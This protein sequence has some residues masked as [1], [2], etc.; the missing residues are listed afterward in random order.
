MHWAEIYNMPNISFR[1]FNAY[2]PRS[3][4]TGA[5]GAVFEF[6]LHKGLQ[7]NL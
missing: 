6:S 1:F 4:T 7:T 2:G 3:R 5:Y